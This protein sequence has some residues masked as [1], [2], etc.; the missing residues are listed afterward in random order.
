[1]SLI[2]KVRASEQAGAGWLSGI[3]PRKG[4]IML[5]LSRREGEKLIIG[6][7]V[8][9]TILAVKGNQVRIGIDAPREVKIDREEIYQRKQ[10][11]KKALTGSKRIN[12]PFSEARVPART[13]L[14][15]DKRSK[16]RDKGLIAE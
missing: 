16:E 12:I 3:A 5:V 2:R 6:G 14:P 9:V 4:I 13:L 11:E 7:N 15:S 8:T 1:M 10:K